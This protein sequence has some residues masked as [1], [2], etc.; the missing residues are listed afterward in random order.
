M[1]VTGYGWLVLA[2]PLAGMLVVALGWRV[3]PGRTAGWV[4]SAAIGGAFAS[5]IGMLLQL[6]DKPEESRSLVGTAY[7]YADTAG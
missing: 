2:F 6:L 5:S 4:A 3:L 7:T 1:N